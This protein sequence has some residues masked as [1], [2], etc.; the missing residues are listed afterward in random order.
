MSTTVPEAVEAEATAIVAAGKY[1]RRRGRLEN[2]DGKFDKGGRWYPADGEWRD[3]CNRI[4]Y[5]SRAYP[6]S[7]MKHC[8]SVEHVAA[9]CNADVRLVR[10]AARSL[11]I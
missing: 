2:P 8:R 1:L 9:L 10:R 4:R 3:C 11:T 6:Y 7:Y 5:P